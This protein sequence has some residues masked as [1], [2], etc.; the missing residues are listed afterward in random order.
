ME[1]AVETGSNHLWDRVQVQESTVRQDEDL[2]E[3]DDGVHLASI[4]SEKNSS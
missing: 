4:S 3:R 2:G 1:S